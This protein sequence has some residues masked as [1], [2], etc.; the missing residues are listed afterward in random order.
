MGDIPFSLAYETK[1]I[2]PFEIH[3]P[4]LHSH[5]SQG[6]NDDIQ[7]EDILLVEEKKCVL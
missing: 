7:R 2:I 3:E 4:T 5:I 1:V 6:D